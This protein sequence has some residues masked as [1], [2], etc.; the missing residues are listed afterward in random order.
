MLTPRVTVVVLVPAMDD[1]KNIRYIS[2]LLAC[3]Q[4]LSLLTQND[5]AD[6]KMHMSQTAGSLFCC[7]CCTQAVGKRV[8]K[9]P[10]CQYLMLCH[11]IE[12]T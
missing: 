5:G 11:S 10:G 1:T 3:F 9:H 8:Y 12:V 6:V 2:S 4:A 7:C